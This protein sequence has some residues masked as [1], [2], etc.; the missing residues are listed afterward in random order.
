MTNE[1]CTGPPRQAVPLVLLEIILLV[2]P[3]ASIRAKDPGVRA[4]PGAE[5]AGAMARGGR[6]GQALFV[7]NLND[8][9]AGSFRAAV[10]AR[11]PRIVLFRV[12]G[13]IELERPVRIS[14][15]YITIAGQ[16]APGD[17]VCLKN[18]SLEIGST[19]EVIIRHLR[20]R[21]G[22]KTSGPGE[23][24]A[25]TI[26][27]S[28]NVILDHCS[29]TWSTDECL[30]VT[31]DCDNV[32]I[33]WCLIAEG[34]TSHSMGSIIGSYRGKITYHRN[35]Y[36]NNRSRNPRISAHN[37]EEG[38]QDDPGPL[39]DFRHNVIF[40]WAWAAGYAGGSDPKMR[41]LT[42][43]NYV[44]NYLKPGPDTRPG[45]R[46][47]VYRVNVGATTRMY[48]AENV[49]EGFVNE[50]RNGSMIH[51]DGGRLQM[52][53]QRILTPRVSPGDPRKTFHEVLAH[54][55]ATLPVRDATDRRV[56]EGVRSGKG[57]ILSSQEDVG[58]WKQLRAGRA[59]LDDDTDGMPNS[60]ER[61]HGLDPS[62]ASDQVEDPDGDGY[63]N[64]EEYI[65]D[66]NPKNPD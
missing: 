25:I 23:M 42:R 29:A 8:S 20:C 63:A 27:D 2:W 35:L 40:N 10:E 15:P 66:T 62:D 12:A 36:A 28:K 50:S 21:P 38:R 9:G 32:T 39:V 59:P 60:W 58:G 31:R 30:S 61:R 43:L 47:R 4:F 34:L 44:G 46:S 7:T 37:Y 11:G 48:F 14:N 33:Q 56:I 16:T 5:G 53:D 41:E 55:G 57:R 49:V 45:S 17:G 6:G 52:L 65:N 3:T 24:D 26:W 13:H 19:S 18:Y 64:V 54:V 51:N 22:D 1:S